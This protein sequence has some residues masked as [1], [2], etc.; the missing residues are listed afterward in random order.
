[1]RDGLGTTHHESGTLW[2]GAPGSSVT[3][4]NGRFH[5]VSNA[6]VADPALFPTVGSA[7]PALT[8]LTLARKVAE[9]I[10]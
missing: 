9:V 6:Y 5:H 3:D 1:M 2:M 4:E 8:G 7:N 10:A